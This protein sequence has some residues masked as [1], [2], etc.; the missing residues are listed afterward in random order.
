VLHRTLAS[1]NLQCRQPPYDLHCFE[2]DGD[3]AEEEVQ[4][5]AG[6]LHGFDGAAI[7][8]ADDPTVLVCF[9]V[10]ALHNPAKRRLVV[11]DVF[12]GHL[13]NALDG[14][15]VVA[16][17]LGPILFPAD[18]GMPHLGDVVKLFRRLVRVS[19]VHANLVILRLRLVTDV[20]L[21][22]L[23]PRISKGAIVYWR[24]YA[25]ETRQI[26]GQVRPIAVAI[27]L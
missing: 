7:C 3:D 15:H 24:L 2:A 14:D 25:G 19:N 26:L 17:H 22:E 1:I 6:G 16:G 21:F 13:W 11:N 8:L 23:A 18:T 4:R 9:N 12:P 20:K 5:T 27:L 10:L